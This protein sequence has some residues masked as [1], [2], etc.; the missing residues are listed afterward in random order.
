MTVCVRL[1]SHE[2]IFMEKKVFTHSEGEQGAPKGKFLITRNGYV[3]RNIIRGP[4]TYY[5]L[6]PEFYNTES[7]K[8]TTLCGPF[9]RF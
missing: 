7:L 8:L 3:V 2:I 5:V 4:L 6:K 9:E 1:H